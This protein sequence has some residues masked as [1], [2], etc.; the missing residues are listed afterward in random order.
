MHTKHREN[1]AEPNDYRAEKYRLV[2]RAQGYFSVSR[3]PGR[4][5][6]FSVSVGA[7]DVSAGVS[8]VA[9]VLRVVVEV[10]VG[11]K[12]EVVNGSMYAQTC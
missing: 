7:T 6:V 5:L 2:L 11:V 1:V 8:R 12:V 10:P 9:L 4:S 3:Y